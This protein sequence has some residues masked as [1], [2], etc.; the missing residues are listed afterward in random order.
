MTGKEKGA[1]MPDSS[2]SET[3][4]D[5][6]F[7]GRLK[8][9][10]PRYGYRFSIDSVLLAHHAKVQPDEIV[11]DLGTGCGIVPIVMCY[12]QPGVSIWAVEIQA[13]LAELALLNVQQNGMQDRIAVHQADLRD[14]KNVH[15]PKTFNLI[16]TNPPF[17]QTNIGRL[18][19]DGQRAVARHE[20]K[21]DLKDVLKCARR[22][23]RKGGRLM[24]I[25]TTDR[26]PEL[27]TKMQYFG[28]EPKYL[29]MV[30]TR[31]HFNAKRV[32]IEG[33]RGSKSGIK[34]AP[35]LLL[36][37]TDGQFSPEVLAMYQ[38]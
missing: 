38:S 1:M 4:L 22:R 9:H 28:I 30:H 34:V 7:D 10:Q 35:P 14:L 26:L 25:Y 6:L 11:L 27:M 13:P 33:V 20:L 36:H 24:T 29:R 15:L 8:I 12:R 18:N 19:P 31:P 32:L 21:V 17:R 16:V 5:L 37:G 23:L 3:T 2:A